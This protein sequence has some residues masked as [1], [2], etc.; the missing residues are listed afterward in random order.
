MRHE[1]SFMCDNIHATIADLRAKGVQIDDDPE[2]RRYGIIVA[3][4]LPGGVRVALYQPRTHWL[5]PYPRKKQRSS[6]VSEIR[7]RT[8]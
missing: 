6:R 8:R 1:I 2:D 4:T 3:M 5:S 7:L